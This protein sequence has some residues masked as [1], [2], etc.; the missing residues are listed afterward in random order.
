MYYYIP[1]PCGFF[2]LVVVCLFNTGAHFVAQVS[3]GLPRI[4]FVA[5]T[6]LEFSVVLVVWSSTYWDYNRHTPLFLWL[7]LFVCLVW[8]VGET[9]QVCYLSRVRKVMSPLTTFP[10]IQPC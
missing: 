5:Y 2:V 10:I 7:F 1:V 8:G 6:G 4:G 9:R 3:P